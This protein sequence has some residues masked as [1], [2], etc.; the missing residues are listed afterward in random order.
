[1]AVAL[2]WMVTLGGEQEV[3]C[4]E[5]LIS[6]SCDPNERILTRQISCFLNGLLTVVVR[7]LFGSVF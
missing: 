6:D 1:M 4:D 5:E 2:L 3:S 7:L